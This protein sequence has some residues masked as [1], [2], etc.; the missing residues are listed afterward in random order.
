[1]DDSKDDSGVKRG[2]RPPVA[3]LPVNF[4]TWPSGQNI[5]RVH[6]ICYSALQF[7]PGMR[8]SARFNPVYDSLNMRLT[9]Q[10]MG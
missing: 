4:S 7:N 5:Y 9:L 2:I 10:H 1:M 8:G 6:S 3:D